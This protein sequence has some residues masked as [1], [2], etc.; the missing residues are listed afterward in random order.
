MSEAAKFSPGCPGWGLGR[1][2]EGSAS[3]DPQACSY[4]PCS[5]SL[6]PVPA[7]LPREFPA[8]GSTN[9]ALSK[10]LL[11]VPCLIPSKPW[12]VFLHR[13]PRTCPLSRASVAF[14]SEAVCGQPDTPI[15]P[16]P[17]ALQPQ[18]WGI[19]RPSPSA[20]STNAPAPQPLSI[21]TTPVMPRGPSLLLWHRLLGFLPSQSHSPGMV[22][23]GIP[24]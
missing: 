3:L 14:L 16:H 20:G 5:A 22:F 10:G 18:C 15:P 9:C 2:L 13:A 17:K 19:P 6:C 21:Q 12:N 7:L 24:S 4:A 1:R 23:P 8:L 11:P